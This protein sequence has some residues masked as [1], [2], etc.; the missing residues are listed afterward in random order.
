MFLDVEGYDIKSI[1]VCNKCA[2]FNFFGFV[3]C[4]KIHMDVHVFANHH[5]C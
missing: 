3:T 5:M 2:A 1:H 4:C